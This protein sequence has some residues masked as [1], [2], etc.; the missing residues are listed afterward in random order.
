MPPGLLK[1][2]FEYYKELSTRDSSLSACAQGI[3]AH[4]LGY[5]D[6][7][8]EYFLETVHADRKDLHNNAFYGGHTASMGGSYLTILKG[9]LGLEDTEGTVRFRPR[10]PGRLLRIQLHLS[11]GKSVLKVILKEK[12]IEYS[13][14]VNDLDFIISVNG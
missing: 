5:E 12:T 1:R 3:N 7:S 4:W 11:F 6:L 14:S 13:A 10:L 8:W 2:N 9:F